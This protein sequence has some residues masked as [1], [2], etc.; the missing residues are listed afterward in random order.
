MAWW[1]DRDPVAG[2]I[3]LLVD[4]AVQGDPVAGQ[5]CVEAFPTVVLRAEV[6]AATLS[7]R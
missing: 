1:T 7:L 5:A 3:L 6:L 2:D 4:P